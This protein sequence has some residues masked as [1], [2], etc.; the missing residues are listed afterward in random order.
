MFSKLHVKTGYANGMSALE[1]MQ[2]AARRANKQDIE[3]FAAV[4]YT[5][6]FTCAFRP[7]NRPW[8][9][10]REHATDRYS[11]CVCA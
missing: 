7:D 10:H 4:L 3:V 5:D 6:I 8:K 1:R 2:I 11:C 9:R